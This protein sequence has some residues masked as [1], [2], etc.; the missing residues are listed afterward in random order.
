M[1]PQFTRQFPVLRET[2]Q[3]WS[4]VICFDFGEKVRSY[5]LDALRFYALCGLLVQEHEQI[6][7]HMVGRRV[8]CKFCHEYVS[9]GRDFRRAR[10]FGL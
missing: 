1:Q 8:S 6:A 3:G 10:S 4:E 7:F 9:A 2:A 5:F